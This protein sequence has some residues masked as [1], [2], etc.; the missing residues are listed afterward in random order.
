[1][2]SGN[3][4]VQILRVLPPATS[5]APPQVINGGSSPA[6]RYIVWQFADAASAYIDFLCAL[7]GY[8]GGGLTLRLGWSSLATAN[9][10]VWQAA[11]RRIADDAEDM[12]TSQT[13]DFNTVTAAA[14][15]AVNEVVYDN[16]TFTDGAD[17]DSWADGELAI[18]RVLRDPANGSDNLANTA[19]LWGLTGYET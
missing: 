15:S 11:I 13:Y 16:I 5:F 7:K 12:D 8:G 9:N 10:A 3:P 6:E 19:Y 1:M 4:V 18:V 2:A 14:P 17:M